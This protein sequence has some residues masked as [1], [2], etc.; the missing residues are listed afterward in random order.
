[1]NYELIGGDNKHILRMYPDNCFSGI[2]TDSPYE[3]NFMGNSWDRSYVSYDTEMWAEALRVLKP[4]GHLMAFGSARTYHR[5]A[6]A[7]DDAGFE[8]RD[9]IEWM[10]GS[11]FPKSQDVSKEMA[12]RNGAEREVIA[13]IGSAGNFSGNR[14]N[15]DNSDREKYIRTITKPSTE[16][17]E[18][19]DGWGSLLKPAHEPICLARKP[20]KGTLVENILQ[21]GTGGLNIDA[22]RIAGESNII[23]KLEKWSG[24]GQE[25]RPQYTAELNT[26]GRWPANIIHD[27]SGDVLDV[28]PVTKSGGKNITKS[29]PNN[30]IY[31]KDNRLPGTVNIAYD[32]LG[33]A[34]RFYY[35]AKTTKND[36]NE[37]LPKG[38][39]NDHPTVKPTELMR[40]LTRLIMPYGGVLLD[41]FN[42]SGSTG[43]A[44]ALEGF[45]YVG[46]DKDVHFLRISK[47]RIEFAKNQMRLGL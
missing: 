22:C 6:S 11:G 15:Q 35:C 23:N 1:M 3:I 4:G 28:F 20:F 30:S 34:A 25:K 7:I 44:A 31:G 19:W 32:D 27:G 10:Y 24:F 36:R 38:W 21:Y 16:E 17:A 37:G 9:M 13:E 29:M 12:K 26:K 45:D 2:I 43:K 39:V 46:I 40:Y 14:Y 5:I 18:E 42:G 41:I 8:V 47:F 33:T